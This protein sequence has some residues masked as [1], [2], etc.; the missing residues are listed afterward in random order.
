MKSARSCWEGCASAI[1]QLAQTQREAL[2][3]LA[4]GDVATYFLRYHQY[5]Q[6][7]RSTIQGM[8]S[9]PMSPAEHIMWAQEIR[10]ATQRIS[11]LHRWVC[12]NLPQLTKYQG[13][14]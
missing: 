12:E 3:S 2:E 7:L 5:E 13:S 11:D 6:Q 4:E 8:A 10:D 14:A 1:G 9:M